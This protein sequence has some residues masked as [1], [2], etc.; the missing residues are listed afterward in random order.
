MKNHSKSNQYI[1]PLISILLLAPPVLAKAPT[2]LAQANAPGAT[3]SSGA[4]TGGAA[5]GQSL[6][7]PGMPAIQAGAAVTVP[8]AVPAN[9]PQTNATPAQIAPGTNGAGQA[10]TPQVAPGGLPNLI[11]ALPNLLR[12]DTP[13]AIAAPPLSFVDI[14][15]GRFGKLE[16]DL[17]DGQ[18]LAGSADNLHLIARN[19]DLTQGELK[20]LDIEVKGAHLQDFIVD[21]MTFSTQGALNFDTGLLFNQKVLQFNNPAQAQVTAI[22]SQESLNKWL[23]APTTLDRLSATA[24]KRGGILGSLLNAAGGNFG[25]TISNASIVLGKSNSVNIN[26]GGQLGLAQMAVPLSAE[27]ESQLFLKD[28]WVQLGETKLKT[29]GQEISPQLSDLLVKKINNL[30]NLGH[31]SDDIHFAF[32]DL[33]VNPG[34][35]LVVTGT[36]QINRLRFGRAG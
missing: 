33:K 27:L 29:A 34:R 12:A 28:G 25:L 32:T 36:A 15:S 22:I 20:S 13:G 16:I 23:K 17:Q 35:G 4:L 8:L 24:S 26:A 7:Y 11:P 19:M 30:S 18:F 14:N 21:K 3:A 9:P 6:S 5:G 10:T 1:G 31:R 2:N